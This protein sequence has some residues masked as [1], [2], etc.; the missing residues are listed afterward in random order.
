[1]P[2]GSN[3]RSNNMRIILYGDDWRSDRRKIRLGFKLNLTHYDGVNDHHIRDHHT[4]RSSDVLTTLSYCTLYLWYIVLLFYSYMYI[5][6]NF[7]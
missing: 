2:S 3:E 4:T 7:L 6:F 1:M 5:L